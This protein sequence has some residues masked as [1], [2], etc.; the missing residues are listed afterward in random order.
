MRDAETASR[1]T[2]VD[3]A[4]EL[5]RLARLHDSGALSDEEFARAKDAALG[6]G[7]A[8]S[9]AVPADREAV[10]RRD[11]RP[12]AGEP[13]VDRGTADEPVTA[14]REEVGTAPPRRGILGRRNRE[15]V[16]TTDTTDRS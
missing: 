16:G 13:V 15:P 4:A 8:R 14:E 12:A 1:G 9:D 11:A 6:R 10:G 2:T 7:G 5:E 3:I